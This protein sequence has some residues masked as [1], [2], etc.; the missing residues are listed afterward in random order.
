MLG[1]AWETMLPFFV[2]CY[3]A[4]DAENA[5]TVSDAM[6]ENATGPRSVSSDAGTVVQHSITEQIAVKK[7]LST[8][9]AN[10]NNSFFGMRCKKVV[11]PGSV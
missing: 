6:V 1:A 9:G 3:M 11:P 5:A 8:S 7:H 2:W 10:T 4:T